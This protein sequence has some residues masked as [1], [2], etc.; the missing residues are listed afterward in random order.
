M[1]KGRSSGI[2]KVRKDAADSAGEKRGVRAREPPVSGEFG[3][4]ER[5]NTEKTVDISK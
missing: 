4:E 1:E 3:R 2:G 5:K